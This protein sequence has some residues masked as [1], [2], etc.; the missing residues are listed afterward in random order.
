MTPAQAA[1][2]LRKKEA[3]YR[4]AAAV[5]NNA[6]IRPTITS[7]S[8]CASLEAVHTQTAD[9]MAVG[10]EAI[11]LLAYLFTPNDM[12][13]MRIHGLLDRWHGEDSFLDWVRAARAKEGK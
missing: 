1:A 6:K 10:A 9:G 12:S 11:E 13:E 8:A 3:S 7:E 4:R 5:W 2:V